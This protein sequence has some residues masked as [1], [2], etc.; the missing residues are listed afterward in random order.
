M[1]TCSPQGPEND[2]I[3]YTSTFDP[4]IG[5]VMPYQY[6]YIYS[7]VPVASATYRW[8]F[9]LMTS[10]PITSSPTFTCSANS[11]AGLVLS[12]QFDFS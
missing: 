3:T 2:C 11:P 7:F 8:S 9:S 4:S 6:G 1:G 10:A 12:Q 5:S